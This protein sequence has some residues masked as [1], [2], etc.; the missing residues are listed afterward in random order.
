M[1]ATMVELEATT[2]DSWMSATSK[3]AVSISSGAT[4]TPEIFSCRSA[5]PVIRNTRRAS[6]EPHASSMKQ[7]RSPVL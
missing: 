5:R 7:P 1:K 2:A 3:I 4:R 6:P